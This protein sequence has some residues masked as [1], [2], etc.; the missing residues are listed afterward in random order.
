MTSVPRTTPVE[1]VRELYE[2]GRL[3]EAA[4]KEADACDRDG[5]DVTAA[6]LRDLSNL[7]NPVSHDA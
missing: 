7:L 2:Q 5:Y 3:V 4:R 1:S 6:I